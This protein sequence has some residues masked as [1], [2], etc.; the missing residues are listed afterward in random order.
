MSFN[1]R[2]VTRKQQTLRLTL[3]HL[4]TITTG[5]FETWTDRAGKAVGHGHFVWLYQI[6]HNRR[7]L[8]PTVLILVVMLKTVIVFGGVFIL[9]SPFWWGFPFPIGGVFMPITSNT[10]SSFATSMMPIIGV[11]MPRLQG[12]G[13]AKEIK[14]QEVE[15]SN[16]MPDASCHNP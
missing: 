13:I 2:E 14:H 5:V 4:T 6:Q 12:K 1:T 8:R 3:E 9:R 16:I 10:T 15:T 7:H 11:W